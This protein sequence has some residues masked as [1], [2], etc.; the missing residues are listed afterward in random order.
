M[1]LKYETLGSNIDNPISLSGK[2]RNFHGNLTANYDEINH[3]NG[4]TVAVVITLIM[5]QF[6]Q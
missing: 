6:M 3:G 1:L 5:P 2:P 4:P